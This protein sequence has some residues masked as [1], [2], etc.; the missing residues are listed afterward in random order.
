[1]QQVP[2]TGFRE[3]KKKEGEK[4]G[5]KKKEAAQAMTTNSEKDGW[6]LKHPLQGAA[7]GGYRTRYRP[8][9]MATL[10]DTVQWATAGLS[11]LQCSYGRLL[12]PVTSGPQP[13]FGAPQP[14]VWPIPNSCR[15]PGTLF[16]HRA[17]TSNSQLFL[18]TSNS[19]Y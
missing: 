2:V 15:C 5:K 1:M 7:S 18:F 4:E 17:V 6:W 19:L 3:R 10:Q 14:H 12:Q 11:R 9:Y 16:C 13:V 8:R